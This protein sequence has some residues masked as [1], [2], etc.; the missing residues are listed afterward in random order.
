MRDYLIDRW[1]EDIAGDIKP[2]AIQRWLKSLNAESKLAW[3][4]IAKVRGIMSRIYKNKCV[5]GSD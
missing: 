1:G 3:T 2:L 4:S 5:C